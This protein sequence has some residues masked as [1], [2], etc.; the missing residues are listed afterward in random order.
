M[1]CTLDTDSI[2]RW[3]WYPIYLTQLG[4]SFYFAVY[5]TIKYYGPKDIHGSPLPWVSVVGGGCA[6]ALS[7]VV[8]FPID[9]VKSLVQRDALKNDPMTSKQLVRERFREM[10]I[11]GFYRGLSMQLLR[12]VPVHS[13]NFYVYESVLSYCKLYKT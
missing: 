4:T 11:A 8:V 10:G 1:D 2:C 5:E 6:G 12:S 9:V 7:W 13:L 3:M